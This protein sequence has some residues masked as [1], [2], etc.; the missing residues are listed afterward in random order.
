MAL[1][2]LA[3]SSGKFLISTGV[4]LIIFSIFLLNLVNSTDVLKDSLKS[5]L[6]SEELIREVVDTSKLSY[7]EIKVLC[8]SNPKQEGC[9]LINNP[10]K[11]AEEHVDNQLKS[12]LQDLNQTTDKLKKSNII[13][14]I[15]IL[16]GIGLVHLGTVNFF[17]ADY[18]ISSTVFFSVLFLVL[19]FNF[20]PNFLSFVVDR[21]LL[22]VLNSNGFTGKVSTQLLDVSLNSINKWLKLPTENILGICIIILMLSLISSIVFLILK[23]KFPNQKN[24]TKKKIQ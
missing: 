13:S 1:K 24:K 15:L 22:P 21:L 10:S 23:R 4:T 8:D 19:F 2:L 14:I 16:I 12:I 17:E 9:D 11:L 3:R 6:D 18:K 7:D 20:L 5:S